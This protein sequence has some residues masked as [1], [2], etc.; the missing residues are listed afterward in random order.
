MKGRRL[1]DSLE[2]G[3]DPEQIHAPVRAAGG[4][5]APQDQPR[6]R[7]RDQQP[8]AS[9]Q[10]EVG[11]DDQVPPLGSVQRAIVGMIAKLR[12]RDQPSLPA[13]K[14]RHDFHRLHQRRGIVRT[15]QALNRH[16]LV[17]GSD[18]D[19]KIVI[20]EEEA[21]ARIARRKGKPQ[22]IPAIGLDPRGTETV[23]IRLDVDV[24][25]FGALRCHGGK[26]GGEGRPGN[27]NQQRRQPPGRWTCRPRDPVRTA[28]AL[29]GGSDRIGKTTEAGS[30]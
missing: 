24:P 18:G 12:F 5:A 19:V 13:R 2:P 30:V 6:E 28:G 16:Q 14:S 26:P 1:Q 9:V 22:A 27:Q 10:Q 8:Q 17:A 7:N 3:K 4:P 29:A 21:L 20:L 23:A 15:R 25:R 11:R